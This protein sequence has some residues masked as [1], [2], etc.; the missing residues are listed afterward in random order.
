M[1]LNS[2]LFFLFFKVETLISMFPKPIIEH[3][4]RVNKEIMEQLD[5]VAETANRAYA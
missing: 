2:I 5:R 1:F 4:K 3:G